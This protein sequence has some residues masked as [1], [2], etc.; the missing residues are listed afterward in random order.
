MLKGPKPLQEKQ[1]TQQGEIKQQGGQSV[2]DN[3]GG[4]H[5]PQYGENRAGKGWHRRRHSEAV[6]DEPEGG[7]RDAHE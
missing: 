1:R 7:F 2:N 3:Q 5:P 6:R 4:A